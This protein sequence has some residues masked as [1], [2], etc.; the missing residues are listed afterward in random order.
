VSVQQT[1]SDTDKKKKKTKTK[2]SKTEKPVL[3]TKS[4]DGDTCA[5]K[6]EKLD[7]LS[8]QQ[9]IEFFSKDHNFVDLSSLNVRC[10]PLFRLTTTELAPLSEIQTYSSNNS[11]DS[12]NSDRSNAKLVGYLRVTEKSFNV[13]VVQKGDGVFLQFDDLPEQCWYRVTTERALREFVE[14]YSISEAPRDTAE[15]RLP[16]KT[17]RY[18]LQRNSSF[19]PIMMERYMLINKFLTKNIHGELCHQQVVLYSHKLNTFNMATK[20]YEISM[21]QTNEDGDYF[22]LTSYGFYSGASVTVQISPC[23]VVAHIQYS[24]TPAHHDLIAKI[25]SKH[26]CCMDEDLPLDVV[27]F[28]LPFTPIDQNWM[29]NLIKKGAKLTIPM[30]YM[31]TWLRTDGVLTS[32]NVPEDCE[33]TTTSM[34]SIL[35]ELYNIAKK[36]DRYDEDDAFL[37]GSLLKKQISL[38]YIRNSK[39]ELITDNRSDEG[40]DGTAENKEQK[41]ESDVSRTHELYSAVI[42]AVENAG[43]LK[44]VDKKFIKTEIAGMFSE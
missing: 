19:R 15:S 39:D 2:A 22:E 11:S 16:T 4:H 26:N 35:K 14:Y 30:I 9:V 37:V 18:D 8:S 33:A 24:P 5:D 21:R 29:I 7:L 1:M 36:D 17:V 43:D 10:S 28:L 41:K 27:L 44:Y 23:G 42:K 34:I 12:D 20:F 31:I 40:E 3:S 6:T 38:E 32:N 13:N 25:N